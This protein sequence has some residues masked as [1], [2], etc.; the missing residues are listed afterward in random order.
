MSYAVFAALPFVG[1]LNPL[2]RQAEV[3]RD[4]GWRV[5]I[6]TAREMAGHVTAEAPTVPFLDLGPLGPIAA[7]LA[8]AQ[9]LASVEPNYR[10]GALHFLPVL[11]EIWPLL[12]D[13]L[14]AVIARDRPAVVVADLFTS[15]AFSAAGAAGLPFVVNNPSLLNA[16]PTQLLARAPA[17]P[18]VMS[19][20]SIHDVRWWHRMLEPVTRHAMQAAVELTIG[21]QVSVQRRARGL[22]RRSL[23]DLLRHQPILVNGVFGLD[24]E[25]PLPPCIHM[26]GPMLAARVPPLPIDLHDWLEDGPPVVYANLGTVAEAPAPQLAKMVD[27]FATDARRVLWVVR[28]GTRPRLPAALPRSIR[29][30]TRVPSPR[31]VLAHHNVKAFVSHCGINSVYESLAAGTP[32]VGIPMLSDQRD[33]AVRVSDAGVGLWMDKSRFTAAQLGDA[34]D[35]VVSDSRFRERI[36]PLQRAFGRAGGASR[37]ADLIAAHANGQAVRGTTDRA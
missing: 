35:I 9:A 30:V 31:A 29:L 36:A 18:A 12:F 34:I 19:P 6:A 28:E 8:Q 14:A 25:R 15:A 7:R 5:A 33:M 22:P 13:G 37:A 23:H 24:Y 26:V 17:I 32:I 1:H 20:R 4:R 3:L 2:L 21:R 11:A 16:I 27:A 10:R